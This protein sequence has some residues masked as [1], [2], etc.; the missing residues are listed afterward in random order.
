M[1]RINEKPLARSFNRRAAKDGLKR[2]GQIKLVKSCKSAR[3]KTHS[4]LK[5]RLGR[6]SPAGEREGLGLGNAFD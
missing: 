6:L 5:S 4:V 1:L 2:A 3:L